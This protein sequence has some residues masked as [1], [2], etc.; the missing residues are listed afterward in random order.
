MIDLEYEIAKS[1]MIGCTST[2]SGS[3]YKEKLILVNKVPIYYT[4]YKL[5]T[6][7]LQLS[8]NEN[9]VSYVYLK[10]IQSLACSSTQVTQFEE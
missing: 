1:I 3:T 5:Y 4:R 7:A 8:F 9:M 10:D 2:Q 6:N